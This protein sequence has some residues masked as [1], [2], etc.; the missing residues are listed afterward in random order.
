MT[1]KKKL[2]L[3]YHRLI[4]SDPV[5]HYRAAI[6]ALHTN[7]MKV[8]S[9]PILC[10]DPIPSL[11]KSHLC[12]SEECQM[13]FF[14]LLTWHKCQHLP[15][16]WTVP[17]VLLTQWREKDTMFSQQIRK[18]HALVQFCT[19]RILACLSSVIRLKTDSCSLIICPQ[20]KELNKGHLV[21]EMAS[22]A[23]LKTCCLLH[24]TFFLAL[25]LYSFSFEFIWSCLSK[26]TNETHKNP[27]FSATGPELQHT[28][29]R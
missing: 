17:N 20:N 1:I 11:E 2:K 18:S 12:F 19:E 21:L 15:R 22:K 8:Y 7:G 23:L 26:E 9:I 13:T 4:W 6:C 10:S 3:Q 25:K 14:H 28:Q 5:H 16:K 24:S 29:T 27:H